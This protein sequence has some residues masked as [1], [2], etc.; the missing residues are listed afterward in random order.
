MRST[1]AGLTRSSERQRAAAAPLVASGSAAIPGA[2]AT[3]SASERSG[4]RRPT[5]SAAPRHG[6][7]RRRARRAR[8]SRRSSPGPRPAPRRPAA[9]RR[10][11]AQRG[12]AVPLSAPVVRARACWKNFSKWGGR[13]PADH[14]D[15][16]TL[17]TVAMTCSISAG[18]RVVGRA[19][20]HDAVAVEAGVGQ[21][22]LRASRSS[23]VIAVASGRPISA[24]TARASRP[25]AGRPRCRCGS[26][27]A[28][29]R[30]RSRAGGRGRRSARAPSG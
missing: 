8:T 3:S 1:Q 23:S 18:V 25:G 28:A 15:R 17:P 2:S 13:C 4:S 5:G 26:P 14:C 6:R 11:A 22:A 16:S 27:P 10:R 24:S 21:R 29:P 20:R 7:R 19:D 12:I 30:R 9:K